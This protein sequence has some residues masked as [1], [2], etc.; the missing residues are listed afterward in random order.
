MK[1]SF[2]QEEAEEVVLSRRPFEG[3]RD[4]EAEE[5]GVEDVH[6]GVVGESVAEEGDQPAVDEGGAVDDGEGDEV[7][8]AKR[9]QI[10]FGF[11]EV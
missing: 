1:V 11:D 7:P 2:S 5:R 8:P 9:E 10:S 4:L 6:R 3:G